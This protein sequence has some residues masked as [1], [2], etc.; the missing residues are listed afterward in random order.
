MNLTLATMPEWFESL[1]LAIGWALVLFLIQGLIIGLGVATLL[2]ALRRRSA[3]LRYTVALA[4][5]LLMVACP[6]VTTVR[7]LVA[8]PGGMALR[9]RLDS[10]PTSMTTHGDAEVKPALGFIPARE[11]VPGPTPEDDGIEATRVAS[12]PV[13]NGQRD[14][15]ARL[16][17]WLPAAVAF[18][19]L[20][21]CALALRLALGLVE[22]RGLTR[23]GI[24]PASGE[25]LTVFDR[26]LQRL[27]CR[28]PVRCFLSRRVEVPSVV[29]WLRPTVLIPVSSLA[30]LTVDQLEALLAHE[31]AHIRRLDFLVNSFQVIVEALLFFHPAV[32][33]VSGRI[34][35]EREHCCDD[36]AV[37]LCG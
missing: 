9:G 33:W 10:I 23:L 2:R 27:G 35:V 13:I 15:R 20:G 18:W 24:E 29:G 22:I 5:L 1:V 25:L 6:V 3:Q 28:R 4:G 11:V 7:G 17:A 32:W 16:E 26:M 19:L 14:W 34:R 30:R 12:A 31:L 21:V 8:H 36:L 37:D